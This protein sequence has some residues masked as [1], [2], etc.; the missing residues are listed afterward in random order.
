[1][2]PQLVHRGCDEKMLR[3]ILAAVAEP[4]PSDDATLGDG[5]AGHALLLHSAA[6]HYS[7]RGYALRAH[8]Y[9]DAALEAISTVPHP[10][11]LLVGYTGVAWTCAYLESKLGVRSSVDLH[12]ADDELI[13]RIEARDALEPLDLIYGLA[14]YAVYLLER[15]PEPS[16]RHGLELIAAVLEDR[17]EVDEGGLRWWTPPEHLAPRRRELE[18][19]GVYDLGL[20][21]G[22]PGI[23]AALAA[24]H[25]AGIAKP[26]TA[27]MLREGCAWLFAHR[28]ERHRL[29]EY[30]YWLSLSG[31]PHDDHGR[32]A[33]CYGELGPAYA[34]LRSAPITGDCHLAQATTA[35]LEGLRERPI[36]QAGVVDASVCHGSAGVF[37]LLQQ[38]AMAGHAGAL[39][40]TARWLDDVRARWRDGTGCGGFSYAHRERA[41][42]PEEL[43]PQRGLVVGATGIGLTLL[44]ARSPMLAQWSRAILP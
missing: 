10:P 21:H 13:S 23:L 41:F 17:A 36:V 16:A 43:Q 32:A 26:A 39:A 7:E 40:D 20:A 29:G 5:C 2:T 1:M 35:I 22:V 6:L 15:L 38:A 34:F 27:R 18:P 28:R 31:P 24:M 25:R 33:W 12:D 19:Q 4:S 11:G 37:M 14:G 8:D 3:A 30:A 44:A 9:L 42:D